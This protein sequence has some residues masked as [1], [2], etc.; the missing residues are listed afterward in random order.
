MPRCSYQMRVEA[1]LDMV[2]A[3]LLD[4]AEHPQRYID[5]VLDSRILSRGQGFLE[6]ELEVDGGVWLRERVE[7][8]EEA[9]VLVFRLEEHPTYGGT[10]WNRARAVE[11]GTEV[12]FDMDWQARDGRVIPDDDPDPVNLIRSALEHTRTIAEEVARAAAE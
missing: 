5:G 10:V 6:R 4:K 1:P 3:I 11:G 8:D 9:K 7:V 12:V 2:W